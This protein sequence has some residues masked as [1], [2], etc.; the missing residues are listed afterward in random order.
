MR[1]LTINDFSGG[2]Q[3]STVSDDFS[4]RQW[5][6]LKGIIPTSELSFESQWAMQTINTS[7][8]GVRA[9]YPLPSSKGTFLVAIKTDGTIWWAKAPG[10]EAAYTTANAV[11]WSPITVAE[12]V[13]WA[14]GNSATQPS[15][16]VLA[17]QDY[18]FVCS[19]PVEVY[20]Y[21]RDPKSGDAD[22]ISKDTDNATAPRGI[23]SGVLINSTTFNGSYDYAAQQ[24]LVAYVDT[25][26]SGSVKVIAFPHVRRVPT[27]GD[28]GDFI[29]AKVIDSS[30]N[31]VVIG[32]ND[33]W[34]LSYSPSVRHHPY[35]YI[36]KNGTL[37]PGSGIIPRGNVG[38][39]KGGTVLLGDVEWRSTFSTAAAALDSVQLSAVSGESQ[40]T[41]EDKQV[42]WPSDI[43]T[44]ARVLFNK[45]GGIIYVKGGAGVVKQLVSKSLT[46]N[47]ATLT[48][49]G[50]HAFSAG[51]TVEVV[52]VDATFNGT[53]TLTSAGVTTFSYTKVAADVPATAI[54]AE[55]ARVF[56]YKYKIEVGQ[57]LSLPNSLTDI[58]V[59]ASIS[60]T[61]LRAARQFNLATH[62]LNDATTGPYR[63]ALYFSAGEIDTFDSRAVLVPNKT[64]VAIRGLH[65]LDDSIIT[66]SSAGSDLDG[67]HRIRGFLSKLISYEG[68]SDPTAVRIELLRGGVGGAERTTTVHKNFSC[69]WS[70]A[71]IVVFVDRLG[72]V[73]YTNGQE[74]D[75][76][77]RFGPKAPS[78]STEDDHVASFGK[79]L[80]LWRA[81]RLLLFT[82]VESGSN[83]GS[84]CWTELNVPGTVSSIVGAQED[85]YFVHTV[86]GSSTVCRFAP[87]APVTERACFDN[88]PLTITVSTATFGS[89]SDH[90]R[91]VWHRFGMTFTTPTSCTVG[92]VRIQSTGALNIGTSVSDNAVSPDVQYRRTL[93][94]VHNNKGI[95]GE[96]VVPA[97]IG[98]QAEASATVS[99]TGY[100]Q[101][102]SAS[103]WITGQDPRSGDL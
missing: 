24:V 28:E 41:T 85:V 79:H 5:A 50:A 76:L 39:M 9:V 64:D 47:V 103:F 97:G 19:M 18:K 49:S 14:S 86:G 89:V 12:N 15:I 46:S 42:S 34:P 58:W 38:S 56:N 81:N 83:Q 33:G 31:E 1:K 11:P 8:T 71:G 100:V 29:N 87:S 30:G 82:L 62:I 2:I 80:F 52:G 99:F 98:Q 17:N 6:Q 68:D 101:L 102:Q 72:G 7:F 60:G 77:D 45:G 55:N 54:T 40:F 59:A 70:E 3:E 26:G 35:T 95:L 88:T 21:V 10:A 84:G 94:R 93:N 65:V 27:H 67:V 16:P 75:R 96:F 20:K 44:T 69:L 48:V 73:W 23:S 92:D 25:S 53:Y 66:I 78:R 32:I 51:D 36:D 61:E 90:R 4:P 13:G 57:Y 74:C 37:L 63:G 43:S 22:N 91:T